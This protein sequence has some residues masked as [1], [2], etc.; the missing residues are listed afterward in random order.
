[1][2]ANAKGFALRSQSRSTTLITF[3][4]QHG[5]ARVS[6]IAAIIDFDGAPVAPGAIEEMTRAMWRRGP[7]GRAHWVDGPAAF[8]Q[9]MFRTTPESLEERQPLANEAESLI[10]IMDG[11]LDNWE[12]L[13]AALLARG[14]NLRDR[15]DAEL[16]L[17]AYEIWGADCLAHIDGD[18]AFLIYDKRRRS[19]F[20]ARD[21]LGNRPLFYCRAGR[22]LIVASDLNGVLSAVPAP[23]ST[24]A[25]VMA[26]LLAGEWL[27]DNE[28]I[29]TGV[30]RL[31][32]A[33]CLNADAEGLRVARYWSPPLY[34]IIRYKRDEDYFEHYRDVFSDSVRRSARAAAPL[35]VE[36]SGGLDSTAVFCMAQY[37][38][39]TGMLPAQA[40]RAYALAFTAA[41]DDDE[42]NYIRAAARRL[43]VEIH[44]SAPTIHPL[45]WFDERAREERA[46]PGFPNGAM[47]ADMRA[48]MT[49]DGA[50]IVL[51]GEGGD[52][53]LS[54]SLLHY[55]EDVACADWRGLYDSLRADAAE[56]GVRQAVYWL[57]RH[58]LFHQLPAPAKAL[59][60]RF[61]HPSREEPHSGGYWLSPPMR[62]LLDERRAAF[63]ARAVAEPPSE[64]QRALLARLNEPFAAY[65]TEQ[66]DQ[67]AAYHGVEVRAPM[68]RRA[69]VEFALATPDRLRLRGG[70]DKFIHRG[71]LAT[72]LPPEV[73]KR[74]GKADFGFVFHRYLDEMRPLLVGTIPRERPDLVNADGMAKLYEAYRNDAPVGS[75]MWELW[76]I[77]ACRGL[78]C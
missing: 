46:F 69:F 53:W 9:C 57:L 70:V 58:G 20:C 62:A 66:S 23:P 35:A 43:G 10:L 76:G 63:A 77:F 17:R 52:E 49:R 25:G 55:A 65:M 45:S 36:V 54:G 71:A 34:S 37:L 19:I 6:G 59:A 16:F 27:N 7:D 38:Q 13:R 60:R 5:E 64:G 2:R 44:E 1:M 42:L 22:R 74:S 26:E 72:L 4:H 31:P 24:N 40:M 75:P 30:M 41:G 11:R 33:H 73:A 32:A 48:A 47:V 21:H 18:F 56:S 12:E 50:R 67:D 61:L 39:K 78:P 68:R 28:T 14:T 15:S 51:N 3:L 8:G 29:W